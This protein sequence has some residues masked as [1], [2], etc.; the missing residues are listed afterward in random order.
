M[1]RPLRVALCAALSLS[2]IGCT[3]LKVADNDG[4]IRERM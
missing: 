4:T 2:V 3:G 1:L